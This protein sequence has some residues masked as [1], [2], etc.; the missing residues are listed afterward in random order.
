MIPESIADFVCRGL[1]LLIVFPAHELA[2]AA[3]ATRFGDP[4]PRL[5]GRLTL[6]PFRHL[7]LLGS[8]MFLFAGIGWASTPINPAYFGE[9]RRLKLGLVSLTGP[10][11]NLALAVLGT[12][13]F[14]LFGWTPTL[15]SAG[16]YLP[17]P[18]YFFTLFVFL[19]L[20]LAFFNLIP[21]APL[22]GAQILG[23]VVPAR[24][25]PA[26]ESLQRYGFYVLIILLFML[27]RIGIDLFALVVQFLIAP[28]MTLL[29]FGLG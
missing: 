5:K 17:D 14:H 9:N 10:L 2:H 25:A 20:L 29:F 4:T 12:V 7:D 18:A 23:A 22:D 19:N 28:I 1:I 16:A 3:A 13:P 6:N 26:Y 8:L 27:P 15:M 11:T 21:V 24:I